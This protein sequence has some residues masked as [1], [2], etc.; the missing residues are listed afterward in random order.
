MDETPKI[1]PPQDSTRAV[2]LKKQI[3]SA[4]IDAKLEKPLEELA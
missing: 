3:A 4:T 1:T 2:G